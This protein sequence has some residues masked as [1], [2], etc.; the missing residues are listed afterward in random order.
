MNAI[1]SQ[2]VRNRLSGFSLE[3]ATAFTAAKS[4]MAGHLIKTKIGGMILLQIK[5][6]FFETVVSGMGGILD[7]RVKIYAKMF[8]QF[9]DSA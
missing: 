3:I 6:H 1:L 8:P 7:I 5:E 4:D 9:K 2:I